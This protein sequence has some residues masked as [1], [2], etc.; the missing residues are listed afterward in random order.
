MDFKVIKTGGKQYIVKKGDKLSL[1]IMSD[2]HKVGDAIKFDEVLLTNVGGKVSVGTPM[3]AGES[4]SAK[5]IDVKR[6]DTIH[7]VKYKA[8]S[9]YFKKNGHRQPKVQVEIM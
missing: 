6:D 5:V 1:E 2:S 7:V 3:L 9:R 8:K 4:V